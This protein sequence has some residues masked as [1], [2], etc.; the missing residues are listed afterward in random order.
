MNLLNIFDKI[1][2]LFDIGINTECLFQEYNR[3]NCNTAF[4]RITP[5]GIVML[6]PRDNYSKECMELD[7]VVLQ[8]IDALC[9]IYSDIHAIELTEKKKNPS[10]S[11]QGVCRVSKGRAKST[12]SSYS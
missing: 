11:E 3:R 12:P 6:N 8:K 1:E 10:K 5:E 2:L 9:E 4:F 7:K